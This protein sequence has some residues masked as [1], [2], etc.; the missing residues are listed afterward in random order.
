MFRRRRRGRGG[1]GPPFVEF[2]PDNLA[3]H[4]CGKQ[5]GG[6]LR[7]QSCILYWKYEI[8]FL[9]LGVA[10]IICFPEVVDVAL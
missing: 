7:K 1:L 10:G 4:I 8:F 3:F 9:F 6:I 5:E 2:F